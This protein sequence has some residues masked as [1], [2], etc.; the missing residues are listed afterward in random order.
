MIYFGYFYNWITQNQGINIVLCGFVLLLRHTLCL[1]NQ[2]QSSYNIEN[3]DYFEYFAIAI[4]V[5][6]KS[7]WRNF[8]A[9]C[10]SVSIF[11]CNQRRGKRQCLFTAHICDCISLYYVTNVTNGDSIGVECTRMSAGYKWRFLPPLSQKCY[12][13]Y[14]GGTL[15]RTCVNVF[16]WVTYEWQ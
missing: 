4:I 16:F 1:G 15:N 13:I 14:C 3:A 5:W 7:N 2:Q 8:I 6:L 9:K 10:F 11:P 12:I